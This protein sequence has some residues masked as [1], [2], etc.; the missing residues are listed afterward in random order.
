[1][2]EQKNMF[3]LVKRAFENGCPFAKIFIDRG[4]IDIVRIDYIPSNFNLCFCELKEPPNMEGGVVI[5]PI[6]ELKSIVIPEEYLYASKE[7]KQTE[8]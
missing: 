3:K 5:F 7:N 1:M 4:Y 2:S 6:S 8:D